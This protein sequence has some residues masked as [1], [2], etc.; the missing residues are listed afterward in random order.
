MNT[1]IQIIKLRLYYKLYL[2]Y[3]FEILVKILTK[4]FSFRL[5]LFR[6]VANATVG[7]LLAVETPDCRNWCTLECQVILGV[8]V[9]CE[10][11]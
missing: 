7:Q 5:K 2:K 8:N 1:C 4:I 10:V 11:D 6:I 3:T 9:E